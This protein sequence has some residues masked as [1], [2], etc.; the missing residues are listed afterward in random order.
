MARANASLVCTVLNEEK[1]IEKFIDSVLKQ[2]VLPSEVIIVDGGSTDSTL[3]VI[4][5]KKIPKIKIKLFIKKGNRSVGRNDG[6]KKSSNEL[7]LLTDSGC[8]LDKDWVK[9]I[10]KPFNDKNT[11]VVAGY[12]KGESK[13][14]FQK[15]L[16]PYVLVMPDKVNHEDF[17]PATRSM[18]IKKSI[19]KKIGGFDEKL[20]HNEDY[21]FANRLKKSRVKI[22]F[23]KDAIVNWIPRKNIIQAFFMF[24]RFAFGDAEAGILRIKVVFQYLRYLLLFY[25]I[26][27]AYAYKSVFL[28]TGVVLSV[29]LYIFWSIYKNSKYIKETEKIFYLPLIQFTADFAVMLGTTLGILKRISTL[30]FR[31]HILQNWKLVSIFLVYIITTLSVITWGIPNDNHP[32]LYHMD[33]WHQLQSVRHVF[34]DGT[35]NLPGAANGTI[36][37][38]FYT[39]LY[40]IPFVLLNIVNPFSIKSAIDNIS[41]QH[42][43]FIILRLETLILGILT[44]F[45]LHKISKILKLNNY[46]TIFL[47]IFNPLW[48]MLSNYFKYDIALI[49][50]I[51]LALYF[52][53]KYYKEPNLTN[54]LLSGF[55]SALALSVKVSG[56]PILLVY[57]LSYFLFTRNMIKRLKWLFFGILTFLTTLMIFGIPD[58]VFGGY[59]MNQYIFENLVSIPNISNEVNIGYSYLS[60]VFF[61]HFPTIFGHP[62]YL[63]FTLS[64]I[65]FVKSIKTNLR[66]NLFLL[67]SFLVFFLSLIP[68]K[69]F[70]VGNRALALLPFMVLITSIW[71][72][73]YLVKNVNLKNAIVLLFIFLVFTFQIIESYSWVLL[74]LSVAPQ[75]DSSQWV[76]KNIP[77][78]AT[79]GLESIPLYQ[80][81]PDIV[82]KEFYE[83]QYYPNAKIK[84]SYKIIDYKTEELPRYIVISN[85]DLSLVIDKDS[86]KKKLIERITEENYKLIYKSVP[87]LNFYKYFGNDFNYMYSGLIGYPVDISIFEKK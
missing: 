18:A 51:V 80:A 14:I 4:S 74:K 82:L 70:I 8:I 33:E 16:T 10:T 53:L 26:F 47:F 65:F 15:C 2:S 35:P 44:L 56:L 69:L 84:Y 19:W 11:N 13:S 78:G 85:I 48:L 61:Y 28:T 45:I 46:I 40:L 52:M 64:F 71:L 1:T 81:E 24:F 25:F 54:Y 86:L 36:F 76:L 7:I 34:K 31:T 20:S 42:N 77:A 6:I 59:N 27:L 22:V 23:V 49:F 38:F 12:Y 5:N 58:I 41:T 30:P 66:L 60:Y 50:W 43:L 75:Q 37:H 29:F 17:L 57:V 83:K 55:V 9:N 62:F 67:V 3:S 63:L 68:L 39:G 73:K 72:K 87:K 21:A 32:F 79:I